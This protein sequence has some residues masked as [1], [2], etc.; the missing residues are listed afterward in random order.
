MLAAAVMMVA[1]VEDGGEVA[2]FSRVVFNGS[3]VGGM[4]NEVVVLAVNVNRNK[5]RP[6]PMLF[7]LLLLQ[8]LCIFIAQRFLWREDN[9]HRSIVHAM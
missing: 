5:Q 1:A 9:A 7:P 4:I 8:L 3:V 2:I 6:P